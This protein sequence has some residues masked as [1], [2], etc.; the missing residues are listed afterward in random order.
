MVPSQRA[1]EQNVVNDP[2]IFAAESCRGPVD[3][4]CICKMM[5]HTIMTHIY[6][7]DIKGGVYVTLV[8]R[9]G[10]GCILDYLGRICKYYLV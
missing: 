9:F 10:E 6:P 7:T 5:T 2:L 3:Q 4:S 8:Q 1:Y